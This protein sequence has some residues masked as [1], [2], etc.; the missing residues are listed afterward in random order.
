MHQGL[1]AGL[2]RDM[3]WGLCTGLSRAKE[4]L[5]TAELT[6]LAEKKQ[7]YPILSP[8]MSAR[9]RVAKTR[10]KGSQVP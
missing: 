6:L 7:M 3:G 8:G 9:L 10:V 2:S 1:W 4:Y 5:G